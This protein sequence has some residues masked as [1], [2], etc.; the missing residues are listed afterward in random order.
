MKLQIVNHLCQPHI[1]FIY[2][3]FVTVNRFSIALSRLDINQVR[4]LYIFFSGVPSEIER[5]WQ[6]K[7]NNF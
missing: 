4:V 1:E 7:R 3:Y 6:A 5:K 2:L